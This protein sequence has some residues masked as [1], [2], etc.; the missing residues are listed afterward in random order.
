MSVRTRPVMA[1]VLSVA[2]AATVAC[3]RRP[4]APAVQPAPS[5]GAPSPAASS[6]GAPAPVRVEVKVPDSM[7]G[8]PF[9]VPRHLNVPAGW[10]ASVVA[11]ISKARFM[12]LTPAGELL[13][14]QPSTGKILLVKR[15]AQGTGTVSEFAGG[16]K[17]PH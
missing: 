5:S 2:L 8:A 4:A 6:P 10:T 7:R 16:L 13:V 9:D 17:R 15:D 11:R 1:A 14:S 3:D 12:T